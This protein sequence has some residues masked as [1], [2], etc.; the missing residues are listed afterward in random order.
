MSHSKRNT[1]RAVFTSYE[2]SLA[3]AAWTVSSARLTRDSFLPFASCSLCLE[4]AQD[5]VACPAGDIFCRECALNNILSQK[6]E[7]RRLEKAR[8]QEERDRAER[9]ARDYA[10]DQARAVREFELVQAGL[11]AKVGRKAGGYANGAH[12]RE[13]PAATST[14][15]PTQTQ[16][17]LL[18]AGPSIDAAGSNG[19][20]DG[21]DGDKI[22]LT[23]K[24][25]FALDEDELQRIAEE[26]RSKARRAIEAERAAAHDAQA[27]PSFWTPSETPSIS[28]HKD[29]S[30][31]AK[32]KGADGKGGAGADGTPLC[33]AGHDHHSYSLHTLVSVQFERDANGKRICPACNKMLTNASKAVLAK[34]CGHVLCRS[35]VHKFV[36]P[37]GAN[38]QSVLFDPHAPPGTTGRVRCYVCETDLDDA[39]DEKDKKSKK[40]KKDKKEKKKDRVKPGLVDLRSEGTGFSAGGASEVK[41]NG[42]AFQC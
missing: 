23:K 18:E 25:K 26:D 4:L 3:K 11:E 27:L 37:P 9:Q 39:P 33:P 7:M 2:R 5:P 35:C 38:G 30:T 15:T 21:D 6:K 10:E 28:K 8:E 40:D 24:R 1:S 20:G 16:R 36:K 34:P 31:D 42:V 19:N 13:T 12:D 14:S 22:Q 29:G 41:K 17:R 32:T